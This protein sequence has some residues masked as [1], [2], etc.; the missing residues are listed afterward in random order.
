MPA[1]SPITASPALLSFLQTLHIR[2]IEQDKTTKTNAK[3]VYHI[4]RA[5][6]AR[7]VVEA[8]TSFGV[9]TID[10]ALAVTQNA[11]RNGSIGKVIATE[12]ETTKA[13]E[14][15]KH[16]EQAGEEVR[17]VIELR[18]GDLKET[19]QGDLGVV[20]FLH[21]DIWTPLA[22]P[23]LKLVQPFLRPGAVIMADNPLKA[24]AG[25]EE[26]F[27]Y[28]DAPGSLFRRVTMPYEEE[29]L[30]SPG[31]PSQ[32]FNPP[33]N[34]STAN[35]RLNHLAI[36]IKDPSRSLHFYVDLLGMR[37]IFTMNAGPFTIY[38]LGHPPPNTDLDQWARH[39]SQIPVLTRTNGLLE[40][41]HV[42]GS[43]QVSTGNVPPN[44]GFAHLGFTVPDDVGVCTRDSVPL[45]KWEEEKGIGRGEIHENYAWFFEKFAMV[46]DPDGYS[47]EL[48]P[49]DIH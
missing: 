33:Q 3:L 19:L 49:Q 18:V 21:L 5:I 39:T 30:F 13:V 35:Y 12:K 23:A 6:N 32:G 24:G 28:V 48:I 9:R 8:G 22:M 36:R 20:D 16:W 45:S 31:G 1:R 14:A 40:L 34:L 43:D 27:A 47:V 2:S 4:L 15:Q 11:K 10:L 25:Y 29:G 17:G 37:I 42:H 26:L 38:Y 44:L 7:T 41:Y 46:A